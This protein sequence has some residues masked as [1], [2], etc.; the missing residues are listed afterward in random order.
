M[1][2]GIHNPSNAVERIVQLD[3]D[4]EIVGIELQPVAGDEPLFRNIQREG[5]NRVVAAEAPMAI[6]RG[7]SVEG[8]HRLLGFRPGSACGVLSTGSLTEGL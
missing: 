2:F 5:R 3:I 7:I 8:D 1:K 4:P 6:A